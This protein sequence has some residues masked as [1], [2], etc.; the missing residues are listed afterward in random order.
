MLEGKGR[1]GFSVGNER[2][3][4]GLGFRSR[5]RARWREVLGL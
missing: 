2:R 3:I 1:Q 4:V 5:A